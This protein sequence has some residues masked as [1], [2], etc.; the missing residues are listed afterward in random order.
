MVK[1]GNGHNPAGTVAIITAA[2]LGTRMA[3]GQAKQ[4]LN[5]GCTFKGRGLLPQGD[6][7]GI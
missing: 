6:R 2:G 5:S 7:N 4:F 3:T 1:D